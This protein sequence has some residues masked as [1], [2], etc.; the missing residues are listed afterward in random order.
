MFVPMFPVCHSDSIRCILQV[1]VDMILEF[2]VR[3]SDYLR[4]V[5]S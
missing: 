2:S 3:N 5:E 4:Y 1:S